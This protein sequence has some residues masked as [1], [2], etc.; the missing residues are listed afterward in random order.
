MAVRLYAPAFMLDERER[1]IMSAKKKWR[2]SNPVNCQLCNKPFK[3][4]FI[5]GRT[6]YGQWAL[7]CQACHDLKGRGLGLG[8]GQKYDLKTLEKIG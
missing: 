1:S 8:Y 4:V 3:E 7:M 6:M 5:D 2:G